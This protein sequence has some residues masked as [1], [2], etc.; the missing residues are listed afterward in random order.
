MQIQKDGSLQGKAY[1]VLDRRNID[2][3][4]DF[5]IVE[6]IATTPS[7]DRTGDIVDPLGANFKTPMPF[8]LHHDSTKPVGNMIFAKA[9]KDGIPFKAQIPKVKEAGTVKDRVDEAIHS[10]MY[11]LINSVSIGFRVLER[12]FEIMENGGYHIHTWEWLE[13]S[14]VTIP[15][16]S[17]AVLTAVKSFGA[18]HPPALGHMGA[19]SGQSAPSAEGKTGRQRPILLIPRKR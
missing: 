7:T 8:M 1:S 11:N 9:T 13:L 14:L 18:Q 4:S 12:D 10:L 5:V 15:A 17:D 2:E 6:G 19:G 3:Q 16:N